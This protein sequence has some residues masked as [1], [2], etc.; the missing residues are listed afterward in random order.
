MTT[1]VWL[2]FSMPFVIGGFISHSLTKAYYKRKIRKI[3]KY[4]TILNYGKEE[5]SKESK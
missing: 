2:Q 4:N 1:L 3:Q 5:H